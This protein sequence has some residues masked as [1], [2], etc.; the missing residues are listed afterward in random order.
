MSSA[1]ER[2]RAANRGSEVARAGQS[3]PGSPRR[4]W[5]RGAAVR[6]EAHTPLSKE[7]SR[8]ASSTGV[9]PGGGGGSASSPPRGRTGPGRARRRA[10]GGAGRAGAGA[11][12]SRPLG[13][14]GPAQ[15][16]PG[17]PC[18]GW[19]EGGPVWLRGGPQEARGGWARAPEGKPLLGGGGG[20][21]L[22]GQRRGPHMCEGWMGVYRPM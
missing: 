14:L 11:C 20:C 12:A 8:P 9:N 17:G 2:H 22:P 5:C 10:T 13:V 7:E 6:D 19:G 18:G 4:F 21:S 16:R 15:G 1:A 3:R